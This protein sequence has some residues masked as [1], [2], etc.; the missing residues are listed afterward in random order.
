MPWRQM[1]QSR[2]CLLA[3]KLKGVQLAFVQFAVRRLML[4]QASPE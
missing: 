4:H 2:C 3:L 1:H